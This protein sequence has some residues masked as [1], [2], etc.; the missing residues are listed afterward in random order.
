[1]SLIGNGEGNTLVILT[2][3]E[4]R[5]LRTFI[6]EVL[7]QSNSP[8]PRAAML[9]FDRGIMRGTAKLQQEFKDEQAR[10]KGKT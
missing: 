5:L 8:V 4:S 7:L 1:M 9:A 10:K 3:R 6:H 2:D